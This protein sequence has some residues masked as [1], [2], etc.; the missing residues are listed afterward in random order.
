MIFDP[1]NERGA[2]ALERLRNDRI[3]WLTTVT[4]AGQPQ[5]MPIWFLWADG[6]LLVYSHRRARRNANIAANPK[7]SFHLSD[8]GTGGDIVMLEG[9]ARIDPDYPRA[10][11]NPAYLERYIEWI[12]RDLGGPAEFGKNYNL[13]LRIVPTRG[14]SFAG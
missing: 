1:D 12:D 11:E 13:P 4:L 7:V 10:P 14:V 3:A 9:E 8:D 5:T 2:R 6:E